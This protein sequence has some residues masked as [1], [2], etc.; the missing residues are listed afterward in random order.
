MNQ[1]ER[2]QHNLEVLGFNTSTTLENCV[3]ALIE[4]HLLMMQEIE[5]D[6]KEYFKKELK[7]VISIPTN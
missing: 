5:M 6:N 7:R 1:R 4:E 3:E 2:I